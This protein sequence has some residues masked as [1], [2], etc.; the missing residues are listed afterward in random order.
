MPGPTLADIWRVYT[1][2]SMDGR[3]I[4]R[5]KTV[6][7]RSPKVLERNREFAQAKIAKRAH[8]MCASA[9]LV[10][11]DGKCPWKFFVRFLR[12]AAREAGL[13][14]GGGSARYMGL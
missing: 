5:K 11:S 9:G 13:T 3:V 12:E 10:G 14:K 1:K 6:N 7:R 8:E 4:I 2:P